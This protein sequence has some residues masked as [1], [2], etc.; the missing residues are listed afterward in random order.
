MGNRFRA[1]AKKLEQ[2]KRFLIVVEGEATEKQYLEAIRRSLRL[3]EGNLEIVHEGCTSPKEIVAAAKKKKAAQ[4]SDPY[5][6]V[7]CVFD[8]DQNTPQTLS[9]AFQM[10]KAN[11]IFIALSNPCFELW[12]LLHEKEHT[13]SISTKEVQH[14]CFE[15]GLVNEKHIQK[16]DELLQKCSVARQRAKRLDDMHEQNGTTGHAKQ[17]PS[18]GVYKL[19]DAIYKAF[20]PRA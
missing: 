15:L 12:L 2:R 16:P 19:I 6:A 13:A 9:E 11:K 10:A 8:V 18:T 3:P 5:D 7:W 17:N 1:N 14:K 20:P 4:K